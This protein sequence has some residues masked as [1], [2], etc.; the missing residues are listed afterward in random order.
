MSVDFNLAAESRSDKGK[1]ASRRLRREGKVP[2]VIYG[3]G[4]D[5]ASISIEHDSLFH[6]L[7]HEAFYS[8]ILSINV[9]G[10]EEKAVLK[11]LQ[12]HP[13][14]PTILHADFMRVSD[15]DK[16]RMSVPLHFTG[17]DLAPGVKVGGGMVTHNMA[18]VEISCLPGVLPEYIEADLSELELDHAIH[19]SDIK[20]P[21]GVEIV[22]LS[23]GA[24]HDLPVAAIHK[25][26]GSAE[27][28]DTE[29]AAEGST[30]E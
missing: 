6:H 4:E 9:D 30:E 29:A 14:K 23:H 1:G 26:R 20:L 18:E 3:A 24:D 25:T 8:H 10:N 12:R 13:F 22:A 19:L 21:E 15:K 2:A 11:D 7:E 28:D 27:A 5:A 16:L 17:E